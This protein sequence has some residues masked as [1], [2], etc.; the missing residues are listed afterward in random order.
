[1]YGKTVAIIGDVAQ[2]DLAREA[3]AMLVRGSMHRTVY[4]FLER[5]R[6]EMM[7]R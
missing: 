4:R 6:K 1:V 3:V 2:V 5:K 7:R